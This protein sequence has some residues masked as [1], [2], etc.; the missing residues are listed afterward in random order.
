MW[1]SFYKKKMIFIL[2]FRFYLNV[3]FFGVWFS[4]F[5]AEI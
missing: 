4:N 3:F 1:I 2:N 5:L